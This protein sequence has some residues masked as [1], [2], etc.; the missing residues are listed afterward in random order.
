M[1]ELTYLR[2]L[3][4]LLRGRLEGEDKEQGAI[5]DLILWSAMAAAA[6]AATTILTRKI[7]EIVN[8]TPTG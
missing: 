2:G 1:A 5:A 4:E 6:I 3:L 7:L 8:G